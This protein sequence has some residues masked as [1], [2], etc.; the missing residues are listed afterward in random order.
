MLRGEKDEHDVGD[1][2][3]GEWNEGRVHDGDQED[4]DQ[5]EA[6]EEMK[7]GVLVMRGGDPEAGRAK[8]R[9]AG[10]EELCGRQGHASRDADGWG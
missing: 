10:V 6:E 7:E 8:G 4:T 9:R 2:G 3:N 1:A 5:A